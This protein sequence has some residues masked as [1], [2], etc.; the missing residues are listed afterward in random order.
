MQK[1]DLGS[2][3]VLKLRTFPFDYLILE[4]LRGLGF[5]NEGMK[6]S[7]RVSQRLTTTIGAGGRLAY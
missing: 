5:A 2:F 6:Y 7:P 3:L 4:F 1:R